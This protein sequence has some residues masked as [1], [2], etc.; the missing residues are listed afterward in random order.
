MPTP[1][2]RHRRGTPDLALAAHFGTGQA[3][4]GLDDHGDRGAGA[5]RPVD[6]FG[7]QV[8]TLDLQKL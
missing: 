4:V 6:L 8:Q 3:G 2:R 7:G 1:R 5:D